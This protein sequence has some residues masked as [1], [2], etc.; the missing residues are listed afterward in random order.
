MLSFNLNAKQSEINV[1]SRK[2]ST[3]KKQTPKSLKALVPRRWFPSDKDFETFI[4]IL[5]YC[6]STFLKE[7]FYS[8]FT[9]FE[10][11]YNSMITQSL[12]RDYSI[13]TLFRDKTGDSEFFNP[14]DSLWY[15]RNQ[16]PTLATRDS[17][18]LR[19]KRDS[20]AARHCHYNTDLKTLL[21][22]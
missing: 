22:T 10:R 3:S 21:T 8:H 19:V 16:V 2:Q 13:S 20:Y 6:L 4:L 18:I 7:L 17:E 14:R 1:I 12:L 11:R 9:F 15:A 5:S